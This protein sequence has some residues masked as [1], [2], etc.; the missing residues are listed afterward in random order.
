MADFKF[1][2]QF[3]PF[4]QV[5]P[6]RMTNFQ[7]VVSRRLAKSWSEIPHVTHHDEVDV[8]AVEAFRQ[9]MPGDSK[10][11]PLIFLVRALAINQNRL[12]VIGIGTDKA[13]ELVKTLAR[14]PADEWPRLRH[15]GAG[16]MV[17]F[18]QRDRLIA[19]GLQVRGKRTGIG[20]DQPVISGI[21]QGRSG[22]AADMDAV[23]VPSREQARPA[24]RADGG[25]VIVGIADALL[26]Y[27]VNIRRFDQHAKP[28]KLGKAD[29]VEHP[30]D[31]VRLCCSRRW[32]GLLDRCR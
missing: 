27:P 25:G 2:D 4:G 10:V 19:N 29:I 23:R 7:K 9:A 14:W 15:I 18:A 30:Y 31:D 13:V 17:P 11:S 28:G 16:H 32:T 6:V 1:E 22:M 12:P 20:G 24:G 5:E 21:G 3:A 26:R 8:T